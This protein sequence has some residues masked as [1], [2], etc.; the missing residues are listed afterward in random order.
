MY[1]EYE[2]CNRVLSVHIRLPIC[3]L[4]ATVHS[5][6][7]LGLLTFRPIGLICAELYLF[8][9]MRSRVFSYQ[10]LCSLKHFIRRLQNTPIFN[11]RLKLTLLYVVST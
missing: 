1:G 10:R 7:S 3:S 5:L 4:T 9:N 11:V 8:I 6:L 2:I